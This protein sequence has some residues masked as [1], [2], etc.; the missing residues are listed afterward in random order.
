MRPRTL[1]SNRQ[2]YLLVVV[3]LSC[4]IIWKVMTTGDSK[5][6]P[7]MMKHGGPQRWKFAGCQPKTNDTAEAPLPP[8]VRPAKVWVTF[9]TDVENVQYSG[10]APLTSYIWTHRLKF[11]PLLFVVTREDNLTAKGQHLVDWAKKAGAVVELIKPR[12]NDSVQT[13][14]Q[15]VRLAA[16][17]LPY[18]SADDYIITADADIWPMSLQ[19]WNNMFNYSTNY[20]IVNGEFWRGGQGSDNSIAMSYVGATARTW[21]TLIW[22]GHTA[23][24]G[25]DAGTALRELVEQP[26]NPTTSE[27][28]NAIMQTGLEFYKDQWTNPSAL[29]KGAIQWYWDQVFLTKTFR[30]VDE[31]CGLS[32]SF[33][34]MV[35]ARRLD[36]SG[37]NFR[38]DVELHSDSHLIFPI[39]SDPVWNNLMEVWKAMFNDTTWPEEFRKGFM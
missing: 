3:L 7:V 6:R 15:A 29:A 36:R 2:P 22:E 16:F 33:G 18:I 21:A 27:I 37:W 35:Q 24:K 11:T 1:K 17:S 9:G 32:K 10:H 12:A 19:Y 28:A 31:K 23:F 34:S 25:S 4:A 14:A 5:P 8:N 38:G 30:N 20:T 39:T 13:L 26:G